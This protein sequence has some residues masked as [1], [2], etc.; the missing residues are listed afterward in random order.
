MSA[1]TM[2]QTNPRNFFVDKLPTQVQLPNNEDFNLLSIDNL[3]VS[4]ISLTG[5]FSLTGTAGIYLPNLETISGPTGA[6]N[7]GIDPVTGKLKKTSGSMTYIDSIDNNPIDAEIDPLNFSNYIGK[8]GLNFV[9]SYNPGVLDYTFRPGDGLDDEVR[10]ICELA[11]KKLFIGGEFEEYT[12]FNTGRIA[13]LNEDGSLN[14]AFEPGFNND[15]RVLAK[16]TISGTE[17]ILAGGYFTEFN[18]VAKNHICRL[19]ADGSVDTTFNIGT[20]FDGDVL[21]IALQGNKILIGGSFTSYNGNN[22]NYMCRLNNDG[23]FD[24]TFNIGNGFNNGVRTIKVLSSGK[25]LVGGFFTD[26]DGNVVGHICLLNNNGA[27]DGSLSQGSGFDDSVVTIAELSS[28]DIIVGGEFEE[29]NGNDCNYIAKL[30]INGTFITSFSENIGFDSSVL[31]LYVDNNDNITVGGFF[32]EVD[33]SVNFPNDL[34]ISRKICRINSEGIIDTSFDV[35]GLNDEV[36]IITSD[37]QGRLLIGGD[38]DEMYN[39]N[40]DYIARLGN[41]VVGG[42]DLVEQV[43]TASYYI[44]ATLD[45]SGNSTNFDIAIQIGNDSDFYITFPNSPVINSNQLVI[46][47]NNYI[48]DFVIK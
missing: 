21:T 15:V 11:D 41:G 39:Y 17:R 19:R 22:C 7:V 38:F 23:S 20:G 3:V 5:A 36:N 31:S 42:W 18:N 14:K 24:S 46:V 26:F 12:P 1:F 2:L 25:V 27:Y 48:L 37:S 29:Y 35:Y 32:N 9:A 44:E 45:G 4:N 30:Q 47:S 16:Q 10:G 33:Q 43:K 40:I 28:G 34:T 13:I 8:N 6:P